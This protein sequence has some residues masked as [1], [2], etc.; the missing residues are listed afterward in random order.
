VGALNPIIIVW[1]IC[2]VAGMAIGNT[3]GRPILGFIIGLFGFVGLIIISFVPKT[4]AKLA[5][6]QAEAETRRCPYCA[7]QIHREAVVCR[8]CTRDVEPLPTLEPQPTE[9]WYPDPLERDPARPD[10][11]FDGG[12]WTQWLRDKPGGT[13][14]ENPL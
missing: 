10:R 1:L 3:K 8:F 4:K 9:G 14:T 7:E 5:K 6:E 12:Q 11:W 2:A 13:T